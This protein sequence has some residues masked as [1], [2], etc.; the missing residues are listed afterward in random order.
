M[1]D[2][3]KKAVSATLQDVAYAKDT[4]YNL[5]TLS[6]MMKKGWSMTANNEE[7]ILKKGKVQLK[8]NSKVKTSRAFL[9]VIKSLPFK[10]LMCLVLR[11]V[12]VN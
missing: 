3:G 6:Y 1:V 7:I 10:P 5:F 4:K 9:F 11:L 8:F 12:S 2:K